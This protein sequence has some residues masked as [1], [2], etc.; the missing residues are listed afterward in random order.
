LRD[1]PDTWLNAVADPYR[2]G[3]IW[4]ADFGAEIGRHP[5]ILLSRDAAM[6]RRR[7]AIVAIVT[8]QAYG[9]RAEVPVGPE[10]GLD[11]D[12]VIDADELLSIDLDLLVQ[13]V[14]ALSAHK[15]AAMHEALRVVLALPRYKEGAN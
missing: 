1:W 10:D 15:L 13:R 8:S 9:T 11:H 7:R 5:C 14:G 4:M 2:R 12:S 3:D 6:L